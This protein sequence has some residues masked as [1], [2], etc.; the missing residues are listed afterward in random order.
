ME[1]VGGACLISPG[2]R[3]WNYGPMATDIDSGPRPLSSFKYGPF[4]CW[5][6]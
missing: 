5:V 2:T 3:C 1:I 6:T 4:F